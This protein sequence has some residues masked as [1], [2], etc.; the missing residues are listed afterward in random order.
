M[1]KATLL[2]MIEGNLTGTAYD[3][4]YAVADNYEDDKDISEDDFYDDLIYEVDSYFTYYSDVWDYL[5]DNGI[6]DF[7]EAI[8]EW[9]VTDICGFACY[10]VEQEIRDTLSSEWDSYE[11]EE[12]L[13]DEEDE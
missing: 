3:I 1:K 6:T 2:R 12:E 9:Q 10:S 8:D 7:S 4:A 11:S 13:E 5:Q